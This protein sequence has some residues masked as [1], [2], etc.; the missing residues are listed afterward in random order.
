M[1]LT[2]NLMSEISN[3]LETVSDGI[4]SPVVLSPVVLSPVV[5]SPV[6]ESKLLSKIFDLKFL[7]S[8]GLNFLKDGLIYEE[9]WIRTNVSF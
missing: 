2:P 3:F 8:L 9:S 1:T 5:L 4:L 6:G 7:R